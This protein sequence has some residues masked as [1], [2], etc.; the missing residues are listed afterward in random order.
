M[1]LSGWKEIARYLGTGVRTAQRW[2]QFGLPVHRARSHLHSTV[3]VNTE[4]IDS[5]LL[6]R[7]NGREIQRAT[8][9][10]NPRD[11]A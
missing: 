10:S 2:E 8:S 3:L 4:D 6:R 1:I 5:W 9:P 11:Q 7:G